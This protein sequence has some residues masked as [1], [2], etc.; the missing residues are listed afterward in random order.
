MSKAKM[1]DWRKVAPESIVL[2]F[3][4][5]DYLVDRVVRSVR[6]QLRLRD[7]DLEIID[8]D[9]AEYASGQLFDFTGPSLFSSS[10][11]VI[12]RGM[13]RCS[14][15]LIADGLAYLEA[16]NPESTLLLTHNGSSVRGKKL[17]DGLRANPHVTEVACLKVAK[18]AERSAFITAEFA[19]EGRQIT[20]GAVKALNEAF[21]ED[22]AELSSACMQLMQDASAVITEEIVD[23]YYGGRVETT[24]FKVVD[25]AVAGQSAKA[26]ALLRHLLGSG[27]N[28]VPIVSAFGTTA[29]RMA[30]VFGNRSVTAG[31]IGGAPWMLE[32]ARRNVN[33]WTE[34][35]MARLVN[36]ISEADAAAKGAQR[37]PE[38]VLEQ[39]VLLMSRKGK[40]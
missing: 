18:E 15:E 20:P 29:R 6:E 13:E 37:D 38:Y 5:E 25:A 17:L 11:L 7:P 2:A 16:I 23:G 14:D 33:G 1:A 27:E 31:D 4:P 32:Q 36:S 22:L 28:A 35:G 40:A 21:A 26:L 12:I 39:L 24:A 19:A 10:K 34:E 9:A 3:G 30:K 8:I